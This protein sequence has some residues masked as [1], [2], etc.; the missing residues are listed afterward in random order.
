MEKRYLLD[1]SALLALIRN[2]PGCE[3]VKAVLDDSGI[4]SFNFAEV[5]RKMIAKGMPA[6]ELQT[7]L[8]ELQLTVF[9]AFSRELAYAA[10]RLAAQNL[11]LGLSLGDSVCMTVA[12][13]LG[14]AAVTADRRWSEVQG[15]DIELLQVR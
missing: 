1:A 14:M 4:H 8:E 11:S 6:S 13:G 3:R 15:L 10:A 5:V 12:S 9:E 2:E 7:L